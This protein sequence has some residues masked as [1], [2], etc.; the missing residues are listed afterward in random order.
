LS[1]VPGP[2]V[3]EARGLSAGYGPIPVVKALDLSVRAGEIVTLLGANGA[4][5]TTTLMALAGLL[6]PS[7]G[8]V[9]LL[10]RS[11]RA[12]LH[13]RS[14]AGLAYVPEQRGIFRNLSTMENLR[15]GRGDPELALNLMPEL[16]PLIHRRAGLLSGGEQQM[17]SV[18]R[19]LASRPAVLMCDELSLGLAPLIVYRLL[20]A[21][22]A[23]AG[24]GVGV[25]LVEQHVRA[26]L[27]VAHRAYVL[28]RGTL[29]ISGS[30]SE[31]RARLDEVESSYLSSAT[32]ASA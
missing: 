19:A 27:Q 18:A 4:G 3:L 24:Q 25:L 26:A 2:V 13:E 5:K 9:F 30:A 22:Q 32:E 15:L 21:I 17:L 29:V 8:E 20:Q 7:Q 14:R 6:P 31:V 10:G 23:A 28:R 11:T 12:A 1:A 16:R